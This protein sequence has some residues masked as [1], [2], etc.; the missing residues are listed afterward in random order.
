[1]DPDIFE[2]ENGTVGMLV[3]SFGRAQIEFGS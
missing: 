3:Q 1:M 2:K